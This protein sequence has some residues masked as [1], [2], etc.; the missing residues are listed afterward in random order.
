MASST[1]GSERTLETCRSSLGVRK[2]RREGGDPTDVDGFR[3]QQERQRQVEREPSQSQTFI[4]V[5]FYWNEPG[6]CSADVV[7]TLGE[8]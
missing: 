3:D 6:H 5:R 2:N 4:G 1:G 8:E 7:E